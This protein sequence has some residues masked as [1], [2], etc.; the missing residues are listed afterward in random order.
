MAACPV[1]A[2]TNFSSPAVN[3]GPPSARPRRRKPSTRSCVFNGAQ[4]IAPGES[5]ASRSRAG[6][7]GLEISDLPLAHT[8]L[9]DASP[10]ECS[11]SVG[12]AALKLA[13]ISRSSNTL[14]SPP[15][16]NKTMPASAFTTGRI[17]SNMRCGILSVSRLA[18][19]VSPMR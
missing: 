16:G 14:A 18:P 3:S 9:T 12:P 5:A 1:R 2:I 7:S 4:R 8:R 10:S 17:S 13:L 15:D 11:S 6:D 19:T